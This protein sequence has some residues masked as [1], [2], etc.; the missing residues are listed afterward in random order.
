MR[1]AGYYLPLVLTPL[2]TG[3]LQ[4]Y[5]RGGDNS[6]RKGKGL[7]GSEIWGKKPELFQAVEANSAQTFFRI[8]QSS[9]EMSIQQNVAPT[10]TS[11]GGQHGRK[12]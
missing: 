11:E 5:Y 6:V 12:D 7:I 3:E 8:S 2:K 9:T 10:I 4:D 1:F